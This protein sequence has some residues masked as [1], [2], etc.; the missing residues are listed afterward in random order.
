MQP[1]SSA[2]S[3][4]YPSTPELVPSRAHSLTKMATLSL[5]ISLDEGAVVKTMQFDPSTTV[6]DACRYIREHS[7]MP[8]ANGVEQRMAGDR[9][10]L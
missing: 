5:K 7:K 9:K 2:T 4:I 6:Y 10:W 1:R 8:D 3:A